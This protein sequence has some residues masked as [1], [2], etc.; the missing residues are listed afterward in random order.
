MK[1]PERIEIDGD[2]IQIDTADGAAHTYRPGD[3]DYAAA[4]DYVEAQVGLLRGLEGL[5][6]EVEA[7]RLGVA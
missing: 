4:M 7:P 5:V 3:S 2:V 1:T 6:E